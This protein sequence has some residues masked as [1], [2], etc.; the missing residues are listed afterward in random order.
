M[1]LINTGAGACNF[2]MVDESGSRATLKLFFDSTQEVAAV[3]T[4]ADAVYAALLDVSGCQLNGYSINYPRRENAPRTAAAGS[5]VERKGVIRLRGENGFPAGFTIP[6]VLQTLLFASG[7]IDDDN[8]AVAALVAAI[9]GGIW[10]DAR[11]DDL[12]TL[13]SA[14]ERYR[15]STRESTPRDKKPDAGA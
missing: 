1:A 4:G 7:R 15:A 8:A 5:R 9:T 3:R 14:Y 10:T 11:G 12:T 13:D 6:G 2:P